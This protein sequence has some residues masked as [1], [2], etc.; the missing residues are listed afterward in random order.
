MSPSL[1]HLARLGGLGLPAAAVLTL[2]LTGCSDPAA[3]TPTT[4]ATTAPAPSAPASPGTPR[5][6]VQDDAA[7]S[8]G[9][10]VRYLADDGTVKTVGVENFPR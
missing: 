10:T 4:P 8:D 6:A 9:L 1:R 7:G 5:L 3:P 2:A